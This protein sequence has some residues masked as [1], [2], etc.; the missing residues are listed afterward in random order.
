MYQIRTNVAELLGFSTTVPPAVGHARAP[1]R[2]TERRR[3]LGTS[4]E[5]VGV[6]A[7][8]HVC[9]VQMTRTT[10]RA[11]DGPRVL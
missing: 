6:R 10:A 7:L 5:S 8:H 1:P 2:A 9:V 11:V 4:H 3:R